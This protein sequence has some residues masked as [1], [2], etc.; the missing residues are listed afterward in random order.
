MLKSCERTEPISRRVAFRADEVRK[1]PRSRKA[2]AEHISNL[3]MRRLQ[4]SAYS[5]LRGIR[6]SLQDGALVLD[7]IVSS[8]YLKQ[9]AQTALREMMDRL[10]QVQRID[11]RLHVPSRS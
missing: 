9:L 1:S 3:A 4:A 8:Y 10:P 5:E 7:G 2:A 11:N 6:C